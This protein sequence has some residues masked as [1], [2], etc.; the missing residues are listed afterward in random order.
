MSLLDMNR[1]DLFSYCVPVFYFS[2]VP[3]AEQLASRYV[4]SIL[5]SLLTLLQVKSPAT[6]FIAA[7]GGI[8]FAVAYPL[9]AGLSVL[10]QT[11][12]GGYKNKNPRPTQGS[13]TGLASRLMATHF[14]LMETFP[15]QL[16]ASFGSFLSIM[17]LTRITQS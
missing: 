14:N 16:I 12:N 5:P 13:A 7:L 4:P 17:I 2:T 10:G 9:S 15:G 6:S 3:V 8:Y 1:G 11:M